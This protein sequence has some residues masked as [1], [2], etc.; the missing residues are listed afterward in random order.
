MYLKLARRNL[1]RHTF[2]TILAIIGIVIGVIAISSLGIL[3]NSLKLTAHEFIGDIGNELLVFPAHESGETEITEKQYE[4]MQRI[5][6]IEHAIPISSEGDAIDLRKES[7]YAGIYGVHGDDMQYIFEI[8]KGHFLRGD[9]D[10]CVV[11]SRLADTYDLRVG[12]KVTVK[13]TDFKVVGILAEQGFGFGVNAD[14]AVIISHKMFSKLY[15]TDGY[16]QVTVQVRDLEEVETVKAAIENRFNRR[17]EVVT[18]MAMNTVLEGANEFFD[19][20]SKFLMGIGAISLVVAGVSILNV[21]LMST[22]ERTKEIGIMK[23][24]GAS[25]K[26]IMTMFLLETVILGVFGSLIGGVLSFAGGFIINSIIL[27][28]ISYLFAPSSLLYIILGMGF[29]VFTGLLGGLYPAWK[30]SRLKPLD[31]LRYE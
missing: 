5:T 6:E 28:D 11:G 4:E 24:I 17:E 27:K 7:T 20:I 22:M 12:S 18:V 30:A 9:S 25:R 29:G 1:S 21:M 26:E 3:G 31:A 13:D 10:N 15:D 19:Y 16:D 8:D 14:Q 2:R 23:A